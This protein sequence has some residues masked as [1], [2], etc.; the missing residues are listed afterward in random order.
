MSLS[1]EKKWRAWIDKDNALLNGC[2]YLASLPYL[3]L[4]NLR[5]YCYDYNLFRTYQPEGSTIVSIGNVTAGGTGKTPLTIKLAQDLGEEQVSILS[6]GYKSYAEKSSTSKILCRGKGPLYS[7]FLCGDEPFLIAKRIPKSLVIVGKDRCASAD[8]SIAQG[9]RLLILDDGL[10]HR[11]LK[12]DF[13]IITVNSSDPFGRGHLLPRGFLR[14][15]LKAFNRADLIVTLG[16]SQIQLWPNIPTVSMTFQADLEEFKQKKV[17]IFCGIA[18]PAN[19]LKMLTKNSIEVVDTLFTSDHTLPDLETLYAFCINCEKR[20][21]S[22]IL[23]TEKDFVKLPSSLNLPIRPISVK[24][25]ILS[26]EKVWKTFIQDVLL[27]NK[28][29]GNTNYK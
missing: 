25:K 22:S 11:R 6:R 13:N 10:Q 2:L 9:R 16:D 5:N 15:S 20:G 3:A 14:E 28:R 8:L 27:T 29:S 12:R 19:F 17:G 7:P 26:G 21:A 24:L 4:T 18:N 1:L 23:C